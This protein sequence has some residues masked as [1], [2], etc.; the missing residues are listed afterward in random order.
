MPVNVIRSPIIFLLSC[1]L[2]FCT[3][4]ASFTIV[5][6]FSTNSGQV[7]Y[8]SGSHVA[9]YVTQNEVC[10]SIKAAYDKSL[11]FASVKNSVEN[12]E[13]IKSAVTNPKLL[14]DPQ[15]F[16]Q[17]LTATKPI[18]NMLYAPAILG[19]VLVVVLLSMIPCCVAR[20]CCP[21][22]CCK[23]K[24]K[25]G[26]FPKSGG[27]GWLTPLIFS[28]V[29]FVAI[30]F[31]FLVVFGGFRTIFRSTEKFGCTAMTSTHSLQGWA[32][33]TLQ[34]LQ[35]DATVEMSW[36][37]NSISNVNNTLQQFGVNISKLITIYD[38]EKNKHQ[39]TLEALQS[40]P[41]YA[42]ISFDVSNNWNVSL[43]EV[44][45]NF[46][47]GKI[48]AEEY[49][50]TAHVQVDDFNGQ[51]NSTLLSL[52]NSIACA[53]NTI[54]EPLFGYTMDTQNSVDGKVPS[55]LPEVP[56]LPVVLPQGLPNGAS[57]NTWTAILS[58]E[59]WLVG[60]LLYAP[61]F[62]PFAL[63]VLGTLIMSLQ[64]CKCSKSKSTQVGG[65]HIDEIQEHNEAVKAS[66]K[67]GVICVGCCLSRLGCG[68]T[69]IVLP[70]LIIVA[71]ILVIISQAFYA[72]CGVV[73]LQPTDL[74]FF[75]EGIDFF[76]MI[77][78][79]TNS[80]TGK[81][82]L[83][84]ATLVINA[85]PSNNAEAVTEIAA[86]A[87]YD[88]Y[89]IMGEI[90]NVNLDI[91]NMSTYVTEITE[92]Q[93]ILRERVTTFAD[94]YFTSSAVLQTRSHACA[95][96][97]DNIWDQAILSYEAQGINIPICGS[98]V[99]CS[100]ALAATC[101]QAFC[102][103]EQFT[104]DLN[105]V[106]V[107]F[108]SSAD[109]LINELESLK[110]NMLT[111]E[112]DIKALASS[113][114]FRASLLLN[115][116]LEKLDLTILPATYMSLT[117][118]I[119]YGVY[120][121]WSMV[122]WGGFFICLVLPIA[123]IVQTIV[124]VRLGGIGQTLIQKEK[125]PAP[126]QR[127][128][129]GR[130]STSSIPRVSYHK[131]EPVYEAQLVQPVANPVTMMNW[132]QPDEENTKQIIQCTEVPK[133]THCTAIEMT[134]M[135]NS[136]SIP[137][138]TNANFFESSLNFTGNRNADSP[139][140]LDASISLS[141]SIVVNIPEPSPKLPHA[142]SLYPD[143]LFDSNLDKHIGTLHPKSFPNRTNTFTP[144]TAS[145]HVGTLNPTNF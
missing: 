28:G 79:N 9:E 25:I 92:A 29:I 38:D 16:V 105:A 110:V 109:V 121:G 82:A 6:P 62:I 19:I 33:E 52:Q 129:S 60:F 136:V 117:E 14:D 51:I 77:G 49:I 46:A 133:N 139:I 71:I 144:T 114:E 74:K 99:N 127:R 90:N 84:I 100:N 5:N 138:C 72:T 17:I 107:Q 18:M 30:L 45:Q 128:N 12:F 112:T 118:P 36:A 88:I 56:Q 66:K 63:L 76:N 8:Q 65:E 2:I 122:S 22:C 44:S 53:M 124:H 47:S 55:V 43:D 101:Q 104:N 86:L 106:V 113:V 93:D 81:M 120:S 135:S 98:G 91:I 141:D 134:E 48:E 15:S 31:A 89:S 54:T 13:A 37:Q 130:V 4:T 143:V 75:L 85:D 97:D 103:G 87:G 58:Q 42:N 3:T 116:T 125:K 10:S 102:N 39:Q 26:K 137:K 126:V 131:P 50:R 41:M 20:C 7:C 111:I 23:P 95:S 145:E 40:D 96:C 123:L 21:R 35:W 140:D 73:S 59:S 94:T 68:C 1:L 64:F 83:E 108:Q 69:L 24:H 80:S 132:E 61:F 78:V 142:N 11:K 115:S 119:C 34:E 57:I 67:K 27:C 70:I 32:S